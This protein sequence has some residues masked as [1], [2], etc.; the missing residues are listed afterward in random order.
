[1]ELRI[2]HLYPD[3]LNIYG[4]RGNILTLYRR[5]QW[6]D[7]DVKITSLDLEDKLDPEYHDLYFIGGGQDAQQIHVCDDLHKLKA[8]S[9]KKAAE[10]RAVFLTIC[11]GYQ[12]LGHYYKPHT[13]EELRGLSLIDAHTVAGNQRFIGNVTIQRPDGTTLVGFENHSGLT[14]LGEGLTPL[15][16]VLEGFGN[17][18]QDKQEGAVSGNLYGTY[19]HGSLLPK[20]PLLADELITKALARRY[21]NITLSPL[22]DT[23]EDKA[24]QKATTLRSVLAK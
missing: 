22:R 11:G 5:C 10:Y 24:H 18:G 8:D 12:L 6:R 13:G 20:N 4:D 21:G 23:F 9:L 2:A 7:I 19:L 16:T 15:G 1:M 3:Q 17:N 14:Y